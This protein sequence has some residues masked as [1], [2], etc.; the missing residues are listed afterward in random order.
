MKCLSM[1]L[2]T[3]DIVCDVYVRVDNRRT[4]LDR[5]KTS[6]RAR[7][8]R[9]FKKNTPA[10]KLDGP[11]VHGCLAIFFRVYYI[12]IDVHRRTGGDALRV[13]RVHVID[14]AG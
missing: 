13:T 1:S 5:F 12:E 2:R 6:I 10:E 7:N 11:L 3:K 4:I 8:R 9:F 14:C